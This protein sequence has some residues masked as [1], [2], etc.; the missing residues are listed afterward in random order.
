[1]ES[2][3]YSLTNPQK[4]I[5][6]T[7]QFYKGTP[8]ENITGCVN[9]LQKVDFDALGK[10]INLFVKNNDS[11]RLKFTVKN[12]IPMQYVDNF[13]EFSIEKISVQTDK[14]VKDLERKMCDTI[15]STLE[16]FLF[17]FKLFEF[18]NGNGGFV[19]NA[20]H[21][22]SDAW[23]AGLVVNEIMGYYEALIKNQEISSEPN[24]SYIDYINSEKEYLNSEKFKKDKI[25]WNE[26]FDTVPEVAT[27][28]SM[29]Q[30]S[31]KEID[32]ASKR[33]LFTIPKE[34]INLI[35]DFC[36]PRKASAFNFFMGVFSLYLS[37]VSN[38]D[39][40]V[41]GTPIL[42][43][44]NFKEKQTTGMYIS[45]IPFKV[46]L[47]S[48]NLFGDFLSKISTDF[49]K[50]FR[51]Q[52]YPYQYL[53]ED[54]RK[55]DNTVPNLYKLAISY[56]NVRSNKQTAN[57]LYDSSWIGNSNI[58]DDINIHLYDMNDT[59]D[60]NIAYDY[61]LSK[62][63]I[64]D[65]CS[66]HARIL[67]IINQILE[68]N[69]IKLKDIEI[70]TPDEKRKILYD[71][72]NT[73][74]D[75]P[76]D[77]T[78]AQLFE[79]QVE[80]TPDNVAVVFEN[81]Q[82]TY[83]ELNQKVN[84]LSNYL[85]EKNISTG[86]IIAV[87]LNK[88]I[89]YIVS[90]L[91]SLKI[92]CAFL[93]ISTL[94]PKER[95]EYILHD[96]NASLLIS[97]INLIKNLQYDCE[98]LDITNDIISCDINN[99][100]IKQD[101]NN[102]AYI[103]YTSG[104][105]GLPKGVIISNYCVVNH[106]FAINKKFDNT[107]SSDDI[108]LSLANI[109][110]DANIQEIF[111]PLLLGSALH[112][113]QDNAIYDIN[114]LANY[115]Y[116]NKITFSFIPPNILEDMFSLLKEKSNISLNKLLVGVESIYSSTLD[117]F[118]ALNKDM[119]I[120]NGYG[121]TEATI[122]CISYMYNKPYSIST[123]IVPIGTPIMNTKILILHSET[124]QL[125]PLYTPGEI[126]ILGDCVSNGYVNK[127]L[128]NNR[129]IPC[130]YF[131]GAIGYKSG[132]YAY[133]QESGNIMFVGRV[134]NQVKIHG[135]RIELQE[136]DNIIK[137]LPNIKNSITI[138]DEKQHLITYYT[139]TNLITNDDIMPL[140]KLKLPSYMIPY[141]LLHIDNIPM[142]L[143]GKLDF[144]KLPKINEISTKRIIV[145]PTNEIER[146]LLKIFCD[147]LDVDTLSINDNFFEFGGDSLSAIKLSAT[148]FDEFNINISVP[149]IFNNNSI[150]EISRLITPLDKNIGSQ[151]SPV[152]K[153]E[154]YPTSSAQKRIYYSSTMSDKSSLL[155]NTSG[156]LILDKLPDI[157]KLEFAFNKL[158][159][160]QSSLRTYFELK[161]N[162]VI[163]KIKDNIDFKLDIDNSII[164]NKQ[165][166]SIFN[167]FI[168]P[169]DLSMAPLFRAKIV[170]LENN[171][172]LLMIDMHHIISDGTSLS[173][174]INDVCKTY[175]NNNNIPELKIDYK[176][177]SVWENNKLNNGDFK[178]AEDYWTN[179]FKDEVPVL[180][181]PTKP[182]PA[183]QSFEGNKIY[184]E[185]D[186]LNTEKVNNLAKNLG[187]TPYMLLLSAYYILLYKYTSQEDIVVGT[188]IVNRS[189]NELYD[190][191]GMFVNSLPLRVNIDSNLTFSNFINNVK[192][193]CL[194]SYKYQSYPFDELVSKLNLTRDTS[195]NPLFDTMFIYQNNGYTPVSFNGINAEY[196]I[197][198]SKISKF[199]LSL[200]IVPN[201]ETLSLSFEY[202]T[203]LFDEGFIKNLSNHYINILNAIL[204]NTE[205]K[206]ANIDML[207]KEEKNKI[208]YDF[209]NT[210]ADY[211]KDKTI[212][213][214][215]E[216]Q[217][218]KTPDNIAVVFENQQLTYRE[219][220]ERANSLAYYLRDKGLGR[221]D[222]VGIM[223]NRSLKMII[224]IFAVI[225]NGSA[226]LLIDSNLP[227]QRIEYMLNDSSVSLLLTNKISNGVNFNNQ[228]DIN[229]INL[230][231]NINNISNINLTSDNL[232]VIYTSGSTG[233]PKGVL[234]HQQG[235]INLIYAFD[236]E[237][238]ISNYNKFL[239]MA[240]VSFDMFTVEVL[241]SIL[242]GKTLFLLSEEE[243]KNPIL[244][245]N[246]IEKN[247]IEF[248]I[249]TPTKIELLLSDSKIA[250][251]LQN[252]KAFQLGGEVF[253]QALFTKIRKYT[254]AKIYNGYGP[255]EV[256]A[257]SSN[258][259]V[260]SKDDINIGHPINNVK[261]LILDKNM[262]LCPV[263]VPGE[264]YILGIGVSK[265]YINNID[266]T[267]KY[268]LINNYS[269]NLMYK[270]GDI[271]L[272][273]NNGDISYIGRNDSQVKIK[274]LRIELSEIEKQIA[275]IDGIDK[276]VVLYDNNSK[277]LK[278]FYSS[279]NN[280]DPSLIRLKL[281]SI[282][283]SYMIPNYILKLDD[284]PMSNNGKINMQYLLSYN[285]SVSSQINYTPPTNDL[286][287]TMCNILEN[288][289]DVK[290]GI[291][292]DFFDIG[293]DS[294]TAINF[295][296]ELVK[297]NITIP[298]AN[299]FKY[300]TIKALSES[301]LSLSTV[302]EI[303]PLVAPD[304]YN[305]LNKILDKNLY[306]NDYNILHT[307]SNNIL[308]LGAIGFVGMHILYNF[309][310]L[311]KGKIYCIVREKNNISSINRFINNLHFYFD[312]KLDYLINKRIFVIDGDIL[313][314]NY[315]LDNS[316][317][318]ILFNDISCVINAA[319]L[320]KHHGIYEDFKS[321]NIDSLKRTIELCKKY[322]KRLL[323]ISSMSISES[324]NVET[325][326]VP[327]ENKSILRRSFN[328]FCENN[329]YIGQK[330]NNIYI[331]SKFEAELA[332]LNSINDGLNA[333]ILRLGNITSRFSDGVFQINVS[334]NAFV[335]R[336]KS[337]FALKFIPDY[338]L[339]LEMEFTPVDLCG[340]A[341]IK[342]L[343]NQVSNISIYHIFNHNTINVCSILDILKTMN[344]DIK[345][346]SSDKFV[347]LINSIAKDDNLRDNISGIV[348]DL[349]ENNKLPYI[350]DIS[351]SSEI[352]IKYLSDFGFNW[353]KID[354]D[355]I[356]KYLNYLD[357]NGGI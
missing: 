74:A 290:I 229:N 217:V 199:D 82:L 351:H 35:N 286:Q 153:R 244:I 44:G 216:E 255:A 13:T 200:E 185:I 172:A 202:A 221:N 159:Q 285:V 151:I 46:A 268:F 155:Y 118:L 357:L 309:I 113:L 90:I 262:H 236:K 178:E 337:F 272:F 160:N 16:N 331:R 89:D 30:E 296:T 15:F 269:D 174:L 34:T 150:K 101:S 181:L 225:K 283:P 196:Y 110:F 232:A 121:P 298:Y 67:H 254:S 345:A 4:S 325:E 28:P 176:D 48:E 158:I 352:S 17:D 171:K 259:L 6:F 31:S 146:K 212:A 307:D 86:Q 195:R 306:S 276:C 311:D 247:K 191:V 263:G 75:Y 293:M 53:L 219:L 234:L 76:K 257:C 21:L 65:I 223:V 57:I 205:I 279:K 256:S 163:Q 94:Y 55:K 253:T 104:S 83:R 208:L 252:L 280:I 95:I 250:S 131:D 42:N 62:Y 235:F 248:L 271:G 294:L 249:T 51:H 109:S 284:F 327:S 40:F 139:S 12:D 214:L 7:E 127:N 106:V 315:G 299:I 288:L 347:D 88:S 115:I 215:F 198:K 230:S 353:P 312:N 80:K 317:L 165:I 210:K 156:A 203:K 60:M 184:A 270:S 105:T 125:Q 92:G 193:I 356:V 222:I 133:Y 111:I 267:N 314:D 103:L 135:Y 313:K 161:D 59:G 78:I 124:M 134:D 117:K 85:L 170:K 91:A 183:V 136:I 278:A 297:Y 287:K 107:I 112:L 2:N 143:N 130:K 261:I 291:N 11:F 1:M 137:S 23:T 25:F 336:I 61:L 339:D 308:L 237:M 292:D 108:A 275:S 132:D 24:P 10:A 224:S 100:N 14:D 204:E 154:Y 79:E 188:P 295:K 227:N 310:N 211:P 32:C 98:F 332:V 128:N 289:L 328:S 304:E 341:I 166:K 49:L 8:I 201:G 318:E 41:I 246:I 206:I 233:I 302:N 5:W 180:N 241:S 189:S 36:K 197:P 114:Y 354:K 344:I 209:N 93:P 169:F 145:P 282:L 342:I 330:L 343:Q 96:S 303:N 220:N 162:Q 218:E 266:A 37:R 277:H 56:Q 43:R 245:S 84:I 22:I 147:I 68:N 70:V 348:T 26:I 305:K 226:Y 52:K 19:I 81:Q 167:N 116:D 20:H 243:V 228:I 29:H 323:H 142:T 138:V 324:I 192:D 63:T 102:I 329:F 179:Q 58:S 182:R 190:I 239:S 340:L 355:Y 334:S 97:N 326:S 66:L 319:A 50:I 175:N 168:K 260:L 300:R 54:L 316:D 27:I 126:F 72:N 144:N 69:E 77:K 164:T 186:K 301:Y 281:S 71:F 350:P 240:T 119:K 99:P 87:H 321:T 238:N 265:G 187:V 3:L 39:E 173:I 274:G 242:F 33:K 264:I 9:V 123:S 322:K 338:L 207:S 149:E 320:V 231:S 258:K 152:G 73:K 47:N 45:T 273:N 148:I 140:L 64:D 335:N 349:D 38:L 18:P 333:Q 122:C 129:F 213:Q 251:S 194:E 157:S 346:I 141:K 177:Y 120:H